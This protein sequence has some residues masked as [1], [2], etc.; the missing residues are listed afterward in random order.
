MKTK[1]KYKVLTEKNC[2]EYKT[3]I[4]DLVDKERKRPK[5]II[6]SISNSKF[7]VIAM[8]WNKVIWINQIL[9]DLYFGAFYVNL[10]VDDSYRWFWIWWKI[11]DV[12]NK[13]IIKKNLKW[14]ELT[15]DPS[16]PWLPEF[17]AKHWFI[18][19]IKNWMYMKLDKSTVN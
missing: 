10:L 19:D 12:S 16:K 4:L 18:N 6:R 9:S 5:E 13:L 17:Y 8:D 3:G 2:L 7:I 14:C 1:I 11:V 15:T